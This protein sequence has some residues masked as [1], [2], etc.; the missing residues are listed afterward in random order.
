MVYVVAGSIFTLINLVLFLWRTCTVVLALLGI[1]MRGLRSVNAAFMCSVYPN[2][3]SQYLMQ[4]NCTDLVTLGVF[5]DV[6]IIECFFGISSL[7]VFHLLQEYQLL[8]NRIPVFSILIYYC[9]CMW[10]EASHFGR[11]IYLNNVLLVIH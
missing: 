9:L 2:K 5:S 8:W 4:C 3:S 6:W 7:H 1:R 10:C 11:C